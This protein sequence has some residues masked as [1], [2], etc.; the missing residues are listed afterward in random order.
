[1]TVLKSVCAIVVRRGDELQFLL[2]HRKLHW[3]G[4]EFAKGALE[5][6]ESDEQAVMRELAEETGSDLY[7]IIR[8]V[9]YTVE[10]EYDEEH[11]RRIRGRFSGVSQSV[12]LVEFL[13]DKIE[14]NG[15]EHDGFTWVTAEKVESLLKWE[16][17]K[18]AFRVALGLL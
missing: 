7:R 18:K 6:E 11:Q 10:Y 13:G 16:D 12:F 5:A 8:K 1:M 15:V 4:W 3:S 14:P 9:P 17:Q 2:L